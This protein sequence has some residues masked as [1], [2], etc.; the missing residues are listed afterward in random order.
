[1]TNAGELDF[2]DECLLV[3]SEI[4]QWINQNVIFDS[5]SICSLDFDL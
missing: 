3:D 4:K 5:I 2:V 1:M